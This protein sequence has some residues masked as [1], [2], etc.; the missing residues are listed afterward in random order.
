MTATAVP[1]Q[2]DTVRIE[3]KVTG[4]AMQVCPS[5]K[6]IDLKEGESSGNWQ[7]SPVLKKQS[8]RITKL[9]FELWDVYVQFAAKHESNDGCLET[10]VL[11]II[12][13][14]NKCERSAYEDYWLV[15]NIAREI[16]TNIFR[17]INNADGDIIDEVTQAVSEIQA[18]R[19]QAE[20]LLEDEYWELYGF[21]ISIWI[22]LLRLACLGY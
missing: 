21:W 14:K 7:D 5:S 19:L 13:Q 9:V 20:Q 10:G 6:P 15:H 17:L 11:N 3:R 8:Q 18:Y 2:G 1:V 22:R 12:S 16:E 4:G